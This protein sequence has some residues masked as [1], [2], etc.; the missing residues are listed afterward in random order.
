M[1]VVLDAGHGGT[2]SGCRSV[3][4]GFFE[5]TLTLDIV[6]RAKEILSP[7]VDVLLTRDKDEFVSLRE[8]CKIANN[9]DA[10]LLVSVHINSAT[11]DASGFEAFTS[12]GKTKSD[13]AVIQ[14]ANSHLLKFP[15]QRNRGIKEAN[16]Y[17][18]KHSNMSA[19]LMEYGFFS[20]R[21]EATC[22]VKDETRQR[23]A[24]GLADG[25]L[26]CFG[27]QEQPLT[28]DERVTRIENHLNL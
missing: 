14:L 7:H 6:L 21:A 17:V 20:N 2:D 4:D 5:S 3:V 22:L 16:F 28:L 27:K 8:R 25:I 24:E 9:S 15:K 11:S 18:L 23:I 10:D 26:N 13:K 1:L 12:M 19:V